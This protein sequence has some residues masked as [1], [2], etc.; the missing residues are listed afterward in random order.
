MKPKPFEDSAQSAESFL[1]LAILISFQN[2]QILHKDKFFHQT[3]SV[4]FYFS[5]TQYNLVANLADRI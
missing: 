4:I 3:I 1:F 2:L 5:K